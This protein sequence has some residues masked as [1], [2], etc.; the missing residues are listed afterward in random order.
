MINVEVICFFSVN[1]DNFIKSIVSVGFVG[2]WSKHLYPFLFNVPYKTHCIFISGCTRRLP[3][4]I[5]F[6]KVHLKC[7]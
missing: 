4:M 5:D 3:C 7:K 1:F 2:R 6:L